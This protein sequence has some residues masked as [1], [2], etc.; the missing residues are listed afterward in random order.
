MN[1]A[2]QK[3]KLPQEG[4]STAG[5]AGESLTGALNMSSTANIIRAPGRPSYSGGGQGSPNSHTKNTQRYTRTH[6]PMTAAAASRYQSTTAG[7]REGSRIETDDTSSHIHSEEEKGRS[8]EGIV[9]DEINP[10][11]R[12][13]TVQRSP[14]LKADQDSDLSET[15]SNDPQANTHTCKTIKTTQIRERKGSLGSTEGFIAYT[16]KKGLASKRSRTEDGDGEGKQIEIMRAIARLTR[17]T[18]GL[19]KIVSEN[20]NT[21]LEIK[22]GVRDLKGQIDHLNKKTSEW[23]WETTPYKS[24]TRA[25]MKSTMENSTQTKDET[26]EIPHGN[27]QSSKLKQDAWTQ[28]D[29]E[30]E[31]KDDNYRIIELKKKI[32]SCND[33]NNLKEIINSYWPEE[34]FTVAKIDALNPLT[35][36]KSWDVAYIAVPSTQE[37]E[38]PKSARKLMRN[39]HPEALELLD[40][41]KPGEVE[42]SIHTYKSSKRRVAEG[43]KYV[44]VLPSAEKSENNEER[45]QVYKQILELKRKCEEQ[46]R[47]KRLAIVTDEEIDKQCIRKI[48]QVIFVGWDIRMFLSEDETRV[49]KTEKRKTETLIVKGEGTYADVLKKMKSS[50]S[51]TDLKQ[52][53]VTV[54]SV[55]KV[56]EGKVMMKVFGNANQTE[57]LKD[58]ITNVMVNSEVSMGGESI[59]HITGIEEDVDRDEVK[60]AIEKELNTTVQVTSLRPTKHRS[61]TATIAVKKYLTKNLINIKWITIGWTRCRLRKRVNIDIC[62]KCWETGHIAVECQGPDRSDLCKKCGMSGHKAAS[63]VAGEYCL[64]CDKAG[65]RPATTG[66]LKFREDIR[67]AENIGVKE[68]KGNKTKTK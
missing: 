43:E 46:N 7:T 49:I 52:L 53:G 58:K 59:Y 61:Q 45:E 41:C 8:I 15:I 23:E 30:L 13:G 19:V 4:T 35:L 18:A 10:F 32:V 55:K 34:V 36:A 40:E 50:V 21:K 60:R 57:A 16:A 11:I 17:I 51:S 25:V 63:C 66:C 20:S 9:F 37:Q 28:T 48:L 29:K 62:Y 56:G 14:P 67:R 24:K 47:P 31:G 26:K 22:A 2:D 38:N 65:H 68:Y 12:G 44:F 27:I 54:K 3:N 64:L 39:S 33:F 6:I 1:I 5:G 42:Y